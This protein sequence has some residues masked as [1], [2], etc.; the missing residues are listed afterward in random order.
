MT[1]ACAL[2]IA[3]AL[4]QGCIISKSVS[5]LAITASQSVSKSLRAVSDS[6]TGDGDAQLEREYRDDVRV[7]TRQLIESGAAH[8]AFV[9]EVGRIAERH[10]ISH[11]EAEPGTLLAIGAGVCQAGHSEAEL[12]ALLERL[13]RVSEGDRALALEGCRTAAL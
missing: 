6:V 11:W 1:G 10:G 5:D 3:G 8:D 2:V 7:A 12:G 13:G 4:L 9:R